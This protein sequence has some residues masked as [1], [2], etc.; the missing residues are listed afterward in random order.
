[1]STFKSKNSLE[2]R[3]KESNRVLTNYPNKI[4]IIF[5]K[6]KRSEKIPDIDKNKYLI[7][8]NLTVGQF[9]F[10]IRKRM[11]LAPEMAIYIFIKGT[12][13]PPTS[14]LISSLYN[15][16]KD[17]DGFLYLEYSGEN[18]FGYLTSNLNPFWMK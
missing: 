12:T 17:E 16:Y 7:P 2:D 18:T 3:K 9:M 1:M 5:E 6:T 15:N 11:Q 10:V 8:M 4:P 14:A 13:V